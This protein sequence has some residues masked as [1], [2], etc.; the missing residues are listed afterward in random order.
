MK[1]P[2]FLTLAEV[3]DIHAD[4]IKRYGG[5]SGTRDIRLLESAIAQPEASF[6]GEWLHVD[7]YEMASAYAFHLCQNHAFVDGNKR[8][9]LASALVFLE[10][11]SI[12]IHDP[13]SILLNAMLKLAQ[14]RYDKKQFADLLKSLTGKT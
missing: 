9:A 8:V 3:I 7:L 4:Q 2:Q 1:E 12:S 6:G 14:G 5:E 13:K 10:L 11:N